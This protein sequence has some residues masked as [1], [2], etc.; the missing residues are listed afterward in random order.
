MSLLGFD[1]LGR[2]AL[3]QLPGNGNFALLT[4]R[5]SVALAGQAAT[6]AISEPATA[7]GF[8]RTGIAAGFR[9]TEPVNPA[10]F[11]FVGNA[12]A[13]KPA[14]ACLSGSFVVTGAAT[15]NTVREIAAPGAFLMSATLL[16]FLVSLASGRGAF[17]WA[18]S[19]STYDRDHEAW[20]RRPFDTMSWQTEAT[21]LPLAWSNAA[22]PANVWGADVQPSN[23]WTPALIDP[24]PWTTK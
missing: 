5:G 6:F 19:D 11:A 13:F 20:V 16:P 10:G 2:W 22:A 7:A 17:S 9:V 8:L 21:L 23:A 12:T 18:G 4:V 24:E 15:K 3:A 1:A 14:Q